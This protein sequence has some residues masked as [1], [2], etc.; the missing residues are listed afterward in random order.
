MIS[1]E[2]NSDRLLFIDDAQVQSNRGVERRIHPGRK[3]E[4]NPVLVANREMEVGQAILGTVLKEDGIY[5]MWY[6]S[7]L[8]SH[9]DYKS[10]RWH[11]YAESN[12]GLEW[13]FP[14]LGL[15]T[16]P[17]GTTSNNI[18]LKPDNTRLEYSN[19]MY[20]P[21][22]ESARQYTLLA[23]R[24]GN[25]YIRFSKDGLEWKDWS[26][27]PV[28]HHFGDVAFYMYDS[29]DKLF[30][31]M[32]KRFLEVR[33]RRRRIQNWTVS[34]DG[35]EWTLPQPAI[36]PDE[37]DDEWTDGDLNRATEIYG[38]P[39][40]RYG[41][42]LL[43]FADLLR[44]TNAMG[45]PGVNTQGI[46]DTQLI[47]SR[48]GKNWERIGDRSPILQIGK[49]GDFD[50]GH[51]RAAKSFVEDGDELRM[52][53]VGVDHPH[54]AQK[55]GDW[56]RAIGMASW[57]RDRLVG[58]RSNGDGEVQTTSM[59]AG[60]RLHVNADASRGQITAEILDNKGAVIQGYESTNCNPLNTDS[61]DHVFTW[62]NGTMLSNSHT[63]CSVR[64]KLRNAEAFSV[65]FTS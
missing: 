44:A 46:I 4:G 62:T 61:L 34:K 16:D 22:L 55:K 8:R 50:G 11:M 41:P 58:F 36:L 25:H 2:T 14:S 30:R 35:Y 10:E 13:R 48:D 33:G 29:H 43:G 49:R 51:I 54:G 64:L 31:G 59:H 52:Y 6:G 1:S 9:G 42:V 56:Q 45:T 20:T 37:K 32:I 53:Y 57:P 17:T 21:H 18:F 47:S 28:I 7:A 12:D 15:V 40:F 63:K 65:W 3:F 39:I 27:E 24:S 19:V 38:I 5:R 23:Y 60:L 26:C